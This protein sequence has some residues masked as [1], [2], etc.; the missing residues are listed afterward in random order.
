MSQFFILDRITTS[1]FFSFFFSFRVHVRVL[2]KKGLSR[3]HRMSATYSSV[4]LSAAYYKLMDNDD[5]RIKC[6]VVHANRADGP[7]W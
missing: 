1:W 3:S 2:A 5:A 4:L 7:A 6:P